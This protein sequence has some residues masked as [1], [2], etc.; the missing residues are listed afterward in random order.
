MN[1]CDPLLSV[2]LSVG[3]PAKPSVLREASFDVERGEI[4]G[5]VGER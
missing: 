5:L 3:Y 2:R 1:A 4:L